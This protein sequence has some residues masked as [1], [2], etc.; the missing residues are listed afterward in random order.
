VADTPA[1]LF[2]DLFSPQAYRSR[3][4]R[5]LVLLDPTIQ[6]GVLL[7]LCNLT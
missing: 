6:G 4:Q 5:L 2:I 1:S 7:E 3:T